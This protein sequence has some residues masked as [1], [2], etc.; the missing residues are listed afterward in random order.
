MIVESGKLP[1]EIPAGVSE[2]GR[3][4]LEIPASDGESRTFQPEILGDVPGSLE[5][6]PEIPGSAAE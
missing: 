4:A 3:C 5:S 6:C 2:M 1:P